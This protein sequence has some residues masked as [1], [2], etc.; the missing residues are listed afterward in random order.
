[1]LSKWHLLGTSVVADQ[2]KSNHNMKRLNYVI[3][4]PQKEAK[5]INFSL[6]PDDSDLL[7]NYT[8]L[9]NLIGTLVKTGLSGKVEPYLAKSWEVF[10]GGKEWLFTLKDNI[11]CSDGEPITATS[12]VENL[13]RQLHSYSKRSSVL[14]FDKIE[15]WDSF[16]KG[17][18]ESDLGLTSVNGNQIHFKFTEKVEWGIELLRMPYFG[19]W[20]AK[21]FVDGHFSTPNGFVASGPYTVKEFL[22]DKTTIV[23]QSRTDLVT[24]SDG[25][26]EISITSSFLSGNLTSGP[27]QTYYLG[28]TVPSEIS[29]L[30]DFRLV[31]SQ[32]T[33]LMAMILTPRSGGIFESVENRVAF[34]KQF[35]LIRN[36]YL[37]PS[38]SYTPTNYFYSI[39]PSK[40]P[41]LSVG[42]WTVPKNVEIKL[43]L[44]S[45]IT[46][47]ERLTLLKMVE[48]VFGKLGTKASIIEEQGLSIS[49]W[50]KRANS[51]QYYDIKITTVDSG[52]N[53]INPCTQMIFCSTLGASFPDPSGKICSLVK[54]YEATQRPV[55]QE[56]VETFNSAL[57]SDAAV[58]PLFNMGYAWLYSKDID[59]NSISN[60]IEAPSFD[61]LKLN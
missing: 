43:T 40:L 16:K 48:D 18:P 20:C 7:F 35:L 52:A 23:M 5:K 46:H 28:A 6:D 22:S 32:P 8:V 61:N 21:N 1:M 50:R 54:K 25:P 34:H 47:Q 55:D 3:A 42:K 29:N 59:E 33:M 26:K 58:I 60:M 12:Y 38:K 27:Y 4:L 14:L 30:Q 56:Y 41:E 2:A 13:K 31:K 15:G 57:E 51:N 10:D 17:L 11:R 39:S 44:P 19:Y 24:S 53:F 45:R 37:L 36:D 49:E 9:N